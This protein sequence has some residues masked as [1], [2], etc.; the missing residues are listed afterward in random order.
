MKKALCL[1][2]FIVFLSALLGCSKGKIIRINTSN[3]YTNVVLQTIKIKDLLVSLL[4]DDVTVE[5]SNM[6]V[7]TDYRD[8]AIAGRLDIFA[9]SAA[10]A[11]TTI[12]NDFPLIILT[13]QVVGYVEIY[14]T[15]NEINNLS[16]LTSNSKITVSGKITTPHFIFALRCKE[17]FNDALIFDNNLVSVPNADTI[18]LMQTSKD[19]DAF[20]LS[21]PTCYKIPNNVNYHRIDDLTNT[22]VRYNAGNY[23]FTTEEFKHNNPVLIKAF[24]KACE[25]AIDLL[26]NNTDEMAILLSEL[27]EVEPE[28]IANVIRKCPPKLE[29]SGYDNMANLMFE[30]G[31]LS[32][33]PKK[34]SELP[35]Y[36][37]IPKEL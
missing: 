31:I 26:L 6:Q 29:M 8:A 33:P 19:Y 3:N 10:E 14:S 9:L 20:I 17:I 37:D 16:D 11:I 2:V 25:Q 28:L 12:E 15:K 4:P 32:K 27:Y 13:N 21:F 34:F 23:I 22:A 7:G 36:S 18:G 35:N 1:S 24:L 5:W 30:M